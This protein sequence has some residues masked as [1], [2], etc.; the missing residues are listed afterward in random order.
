MAKNRTF[1]REIRFRV[2][3]ELEDQIKAAAFNDGKTMPEFLRNSIQEY[4]VTNSLSGTKAIIG[5]YISAAI[6]E[7]LKPVEERLAK[8]TAKTAMATVMSMYV[9][10]ELLAQHN[11]DVVE[12]FKQARQKAI[13][14]VQAGIPT[15]G[16][17]ENMARNI[18]DQDDM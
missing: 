5:S 7:K 12:I 13:A 2:T 16:Q 11:K 10:A 14:F 6:A 3:K 9:E 4:L 1:D 18:G 8:I 17:L 15:T